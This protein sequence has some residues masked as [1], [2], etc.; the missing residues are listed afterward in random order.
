MKSFKL[1]VRIFT[2]TAML[3]VAG[4]SYSSSVPLD[5]A[6]IHPSTSIQDCINTA[7]QFD[8]TILA[9]LANTP[10]IGIPYTNYYET[11][12]CPVKNKCPD[13]IKRS[14]CI[15]QRIL[16][17]S[18]EGQNTVQYPVQ[19]LIGTNSLPNHCY[20]TD[21]D[22]PI[23]D[24]SR[25]NTYILLVMFNPTLLKQSSK[26]ENYI[27]FDELNVEN[28]M[29]SETWGKNA[30]IDLNFRPVDALTSDISGS[31]VL[32]NEEAIGDYPYDLI[33]LPSSDKIVGIALNGVFI[34]SAISIY[35]YDA[36]Y[37]TSFG[38]RNSPK[39]VTA[40]LCLGTSE[41]YR[42]YA[43]HMYSPCIYE[44][45]QR[46]KADYCATD[47]LCK[48]SVIEYAKFHTHSSKKVITPIGIAKDGRFIYGPY[49]KNG[50]LWQ[51]CDVDMCNGIQFGDP[52]N[53]YY[54]YVATMFFPYTVG[55]WG[56][57]NR[58]RNVVP[59]CSSNVQA[60]TQAILSFYTSVAIVMGLF[61]SVLAF[62]V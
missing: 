55:C 18:C 5:F 35:G 43:Y 27:T 30:N 8:Y 16:Y 33:R 60:C 57:S 58:V 52:T 22:P 40:D 56:P 25:Y 61:A 44:T 4:I 38:T 46:Q 37:P 2:M 17:L 21:G 20:Y 11:V 41:G 32:W 9:N 53:P 3:L 48:K 51:P 12:S 59:R 34:F 50:D 24:Q 45:S 15:W 28:Y 39:G 36:F 23:G 19:M 49:N 13:G 7:R 31:L 62:A 14:T 26:L 42:T 1:S 6:D 10:A 54:V 29:C 47:D